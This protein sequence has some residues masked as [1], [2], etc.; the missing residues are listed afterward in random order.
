MSDSAATY[1]AAFCTVAVLVLKAV[2]EQVIEPYMDEPFHVPQAQAYCRGDYF[3]WDPK[4]TTPPGLYVLSV[5]LK[6]IFMFKCNLSVLRLTPMLALLAL[7]ISMTLLLCYHKRERPPHSLLVPAPEAVILS[8]FPLAWFFGFLYYTEVPSLLSVVTCVVAAGQ[9][10]H[11]LAALLGTISCTFRQNNI[12]WVLYAYAS[13]Q[14]MYLRF[15]RAPPDKK[16]LA[17]LHDPPALAAGLGDLLWSLLSAPK[18]LP[19]ILVSFVPYAL[20]LAGFA[21]FVVWNGGIVLGDKSNHVVAFHVPQ[22]YY[23]IGFATMFGWPALLSGEGGLRGLVRS[24]WSRCMALRVRP[25]KTA[26]TSILAIL[27]GLSVYKFTIHHPFLL[28]DNRHYTFYVWRRVFL[29]HPI[30]PY[31]LIPG[32]IAC[33]WAWYIRMGVDQSL[34]QNLLL[35]VFVLPALIPT[36]LLEPRYFL[37]PYILLRAQVPD[38]PVWGVLLEGLWYGAI[39]AATMYVFLHKERPGVGRFMW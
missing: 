22:L 28:S 9:G 21:V 29:L 33:A 4:I 11:W 3:T 7:P 1:Y 16:Q 12:I 5:V 32:Y 8:A 27:M 24:V 6:R 34:L 26:M 25:R 18:V 36:P 23:F 31:C 38:V 20:V 13:S 39:N 14:L 35:P 15:R 2:N 30:V 17:K 10:R 37:I 19:A